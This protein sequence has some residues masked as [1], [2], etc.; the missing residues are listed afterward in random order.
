MPTITC[1]STHSRYRHQ[2]HF[3][4]SLLTPGTA[5]YPISLLYSP[6]PPRPGIANY[7]PSLH[8]YCHHPLHPPG[9]ANYPT[10]LLLY[11]LQVL[12]TIPRPSSF[13]L[14]KYCQ[15]SN[16][17]PPLH[18]PGIANYP[19]CLLLYSLQVL[20]PSHFPPPLLPLGIANYPTSLLLYTL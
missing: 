3:H 12:P 7:P 20:P 17:L 10:S 2:T 11:S 4:L 18:P 8:V 9:I 13:T 15:L 16:L 14:S 6:P 19:T 1:Y 5:N